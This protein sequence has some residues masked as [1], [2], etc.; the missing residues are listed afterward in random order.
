MKDT[1]HLYNHWHYGD[2]FTSRTLIKPL[3]TKFNIIFYHNLNTPLLPD[4]EGLTEIKGIPKDFDMHSSNFNEKKINAWIGQSQMQYFHKFE[5]GCSL[6]NYLSFVFEVLDFYN[7]P[8]ENTEYYFPE[9]HFSKILKYSEIKSQLENYKT[10]YKK[11]V[12]I[13]NGDVHSGQS[14]NF[15]FS[16]IVT[17]LGQEHPEVLFLLSENKNI[18]LPNIK[19]TSD[20][21]LLIPDLLQIS[22]ISTFCDVVVGRASGPFT[23]TLVKENILDKNKKFISFN[24]NQVEANYYNNLGFNLEWHSNYEYNF[25]LNTIKNAINV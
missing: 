14:S 16:P 23:Y 21:T 25:V 17:T 8:K 5:T 13:S 11:I 20:I 7:I 6:K 9:V 18:S 1:L 10:Q 24:N 4:L 3:L 15:D 2:I 12:F 19:F 22:L